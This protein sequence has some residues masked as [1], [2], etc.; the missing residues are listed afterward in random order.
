MDNLVE[1]LDQMS[2][3]EPT[4]KH[5]RDLHE[6]VADLSKDDPKIQTELSPMF[7]F[8]SATFAMLMNK[9]EALERIDKGEPLDTDEDLLDGYDTTMAEMISLISDTER[10][11][12]FVNRIP[13]TTLVH[14]LIEMDEKKVNH[15]RV[16]CGCTNP[17]CSFEKSILI[18]RNLVKDAL[19]NKIIHSHE[20]PTARPGYKPS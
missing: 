14:W 15:T 12:S 4:K 18:T 17:E 1:N 3:S 20:P 10:Y 11:A 5:F 9:K 2:F 7:D 19:V 8:S 16:T 6:K 13:F